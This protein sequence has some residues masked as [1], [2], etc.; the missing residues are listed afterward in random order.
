MPDVHILRMH[1]LE[2]DFMPYYLLTR[3]SIGDGHQLNLIYS[4]DKDMWQTVNDNTFAFVKHGKTK[5][6][7]T[8]GKVMSA[9]L[10]RECKI[11]KS[12]FN[13]AKAIWGD[14][15]DDIDGVDQ[16]GPA[17][18]IKIFPEFQKIIGNMNDV[19]DNIENR[20][21]IFNVIPSK[22]ENKKLK[23]VVDAELDSGLISKNLKLISFELL[24]RAVDDPT[25][26]KMNERKKQLAKLFVEKEVVNINVMNETLKKFNVMLDDDA[27]NSIYYL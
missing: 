1:N 20:L 7:I 5:K 25:E 14:V 22:I 9:F 13:L 18:I 16:V 11:D 15:G 2:C 26:S 23:S 24:S 17:S 6:L 3:T 8:P 12:Y 21:P 10:K 27:L 4:N 19:Y